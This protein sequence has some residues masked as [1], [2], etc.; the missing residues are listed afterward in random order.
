MKGQRSSHKLFEAQTPSIAAEDVRRVKLHP[1]QILRLERNT[2]ETQL[3]I[4]LEKDL[5]KGEESELP[6]NI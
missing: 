2:A 4:T 5:L 3:F 6:G 1:A